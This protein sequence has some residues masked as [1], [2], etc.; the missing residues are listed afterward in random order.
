MKPL[1]SLPRHTARALVGIVFDLD[2]TLLDHGEL[3]EPAYQALFRLRASGLRLVACTG[4]PSGWAD[5]FA[6]TWPVDAALGENGAIGFV[7]VAP[8]HVERWDRLEPAA[9]AARRAR[10]L[11]LAASLQRSHPE[12]E[13]AD[14]ASA[15]VSDVAFDIAERRE[16]P[17]EVVVAARHRAHAAGARSNTSSIHLHVS[18]DAVDKASGTL[19]LLVRAFGED[20]T[21]A[22]AR[23]AFVGDS[24]NDAPAFAAF[25][26]TFGVANV[27]SHLHRL[28]IAPRFVAARPRG[29]GFAEIAEH[30][31]AL[32]APCAEGAHE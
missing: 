29:A 22:L 8:G 5:V 15:R 28:T 19:G 12:L 25:R 17:A 1:A 16:V 3:G 11:D 27:R 32:R 26:T 9:R 31:V 18:F 14:D 4:R 10:L 2:D 7:K 21:S 20:P 24:E 23:W 6:R 13:L 30:V